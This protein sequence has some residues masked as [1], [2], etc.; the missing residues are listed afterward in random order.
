MVTQF[1]KQTGAGVSWSIGYATGFAGGGIAG[2]A[3][4]YLAMVVA[5]GA[6]ERLTGIPIN[7]T[8]SSASPE[9]ARFMSDAGQY[10][11]SGFSLLT[12][13]L[14]PE[15]A[16]KTSEYINN[17]QSQV[18]ASLTG[19][20]LATFTGNKLGGMWYGP[21]DRL[22]ETVGTKIS[23]PLVRLHDKFPIRLPRFSLLGQG[24]VSH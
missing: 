3:G 5:A 15:L 16:I 8:I 23:T 13:Q 20:K 24:R 11:G 10:I 2:A 7:D 19:L 4:G 12:N 14:P 1:V 17:F 9:I 22:G 18:I 21:G 6:V